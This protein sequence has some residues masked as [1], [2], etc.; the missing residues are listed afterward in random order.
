MEQIIEIRTYALKAGK[1]EQFH[2]LMREQ[3]V[4][5]LI[6]SGTDVV[7]ACPSLHTPDAYLLIRSYPGL[8]QRSRSQ[9]Q[10]YGG[11][12]WTA[13][14]RDPIMACIDAY[15]TVVVKADQSTIDG[16]RY[17]PQ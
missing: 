12:A 6:A 10:F 3:S 9:E 16:L 15:T 4:P 8:A 7:A 14:P 5:M 11:A 17:L 2:Q 1:S 13:G